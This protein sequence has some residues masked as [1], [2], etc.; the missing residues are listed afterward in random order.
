LDPVP[1]EIVSHDFRAVGQRQFRH[2]SGR[3]TGDAEIIGRTVP[4]AQVAEASA[5]RIHPDQ[6]EPEKFPPVFIQFSKSAE[7]SNVGTRALA[8]KLDVFTHGACSGKSARM[9]FSFA[10]HIPRSVIRP[11]TRYL[12]VTSNP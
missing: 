7:K 8:R 9:L 5:I 1:V 11:V 10:S 6:S 2:R 12:G 4:Y 3:R